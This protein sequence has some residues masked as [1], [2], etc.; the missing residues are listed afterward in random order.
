MKKFRFF[1]ED[2]PKCADSDWAHLYEKGSEVYVLKYYTGPTTYKAER[3]NLMLEYS[4]IFSNFKAAED[5][6]KR[7]M[8]VTKGFN[9]FKMLERN[10]HDNFIEYIAIRSEADYELTKEYVVFRIFFEKIHNTPCNY[11]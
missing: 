8:R 7:L 6:I 5:T 1:Q 3:E 9:D 10:D 11:I 2:Y 4:K